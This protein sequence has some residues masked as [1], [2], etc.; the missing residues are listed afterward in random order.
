VANQ[1]L[2]PTMVTREALRLFI[3]SNSFLK[4]I[5]RQYD[6]RFAQTGAK[7]GSTLQIRKPNDYI[8]RSGPTAVPQSTN[9]QYTTLTVATQKGVDV[10][11]SSAERA[12]S[13]QD[14]S[15]R[16]LAPAM[17][18]LG[19]NV[20][21]DLMSVLNQANG[22]VHSTDTNGN[23]ITPTIGA[24]LQAKA[25]LDSR[26]APTNSRRLVVDPFTQGRS[27]AQLSNL[28]NPSTRISQQFEDGSMEQ[29]A[30][31]LGFDWMMD[32]TV[33]RHTTGAYGTMPTVNGA[34]QT[35]TSL[36]V[37]ALSGPLNVG[38]M[39]TIAGVN[40]INRSAKTSL[41]RP[42]VFTVTAPV[43]AGATSIPIFPSLVPIS[44][45]GV[46]QQFATTD[47]SPAAGAALTN[48]TNSGETYIANFAYVPEAITMVMADL[49]LPRGVHEAA[50][51][52]FN[53][54]SMRMV[55]A[56]NVNTDQ[57]ITRLDILY[58]YG[59]IRPEWVVVVG[60]QS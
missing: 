39:F 19:A 51:E 56:Y 38:D 9:E 14:Y 8:V 25:I 26:N 11:F 23:T 13:L 3:N 55:T 20:A 7:I 22:F 1:L 54:V 15:K 50:R 4:G 36:T 27:V 5:D 29:R 41:F 44:I 31:A 59:M 52:T 34:N 46:L 53:G 32:Q 21:V 43:A 45:G 37:S 33:L 10:A 42:Q 35:G 40:A 57:F 48:V 24:Y 60:D 16:V 49:E 18:N 2:T 30:N 58:G 6:D 17:N 28:F 12:L 47:A